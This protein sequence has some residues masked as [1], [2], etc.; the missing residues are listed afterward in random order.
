LANLSLG[1]VDL[2]VRRFSSVLEM[3]DACTEMKKL[4]KQS[5]SSSVKICR[6]RG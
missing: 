2:A 3:I 4:A 6:R 5:K 1:G